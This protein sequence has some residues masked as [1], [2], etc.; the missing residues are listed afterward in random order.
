MVEEDSYCLTELKQSNDGRL[1]KYNK[2]GSFS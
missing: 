2:Y 1:R